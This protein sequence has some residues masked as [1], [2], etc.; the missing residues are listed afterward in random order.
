MAF[1][2]VMGMNVNDDAVYQRYRE[3]MTPI[4]HSYGG[5]FGF[6]FKVS[7][8]LISKT[9][10]SI[11]RVFTI[12]FP[13]KKIMDEFFSCTEYL[14]AKASYFDQAVSSKTVIAMHEM[15]C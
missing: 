13:S 5:A 2:I 6:D 1:Q 15:A 3:V 8:V 9:T 7:E 11:N 4:L 12:E 10:D 14:A